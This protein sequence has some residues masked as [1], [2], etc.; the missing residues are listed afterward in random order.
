MHEEK[1]PEIREMEIQLPVR[2]ELGR[3]EAKVMSFNRHEEV[4]A[5]EVGGWMGL[6]LF[7]GLVSASKAK[8]YRKGRGKKE[9]GQ[10]LYFPYLKDEK[11]NTR[12][13]EGAGEELPGART[14]GRRVAGDGRKSTPASRGHRECGRAAHGDL[15]TTAK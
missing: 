11:E 5:I 3:E 12:F 7:R 2:D 13:E 10:L 1:R 8:E 15:L 4:H 6:G 9:K 14:G